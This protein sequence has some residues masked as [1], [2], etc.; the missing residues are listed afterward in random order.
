M[1]VPIKIPDEVAR[2]LALL[3]VTCLET[4]SGSEGGSNVTD[5]LSSVGP[6]SDLRDK[7]NSPIRFTA[8]VCIQ[9]RVLRGRD[10]ARSA[11]TIAISE[12]IPG[13]VCGPVL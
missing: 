2:L 8:R 11:E 6:I 3:R 5:G 9:M 4:S 1:N 13:S 10:L 7:S 12:F